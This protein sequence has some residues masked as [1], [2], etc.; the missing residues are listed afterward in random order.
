[1]ASAAVV[2]AGVAQEPRIDDSVNAQSVRPCCI[3]SCLRG[4]QVIVREYGVEFQGKQYKSL[5]KSRS[6]L[7][8]ASGWGRCSSSSRPT[9]RN[10]PINNTRSRARRCAIYTRRS[11]EEGLEQDFKSLHARR[12]ACEA[13][14]GSQAG[15]GWRP[16]K[17]GYDDG[18]LSV[19]TMERPALQRLLADINQGASAQ[20][21][22]ER[23]FARVMRA[24]SRNGSGAP[25]LIG[26]GER[27]GA[28]VAARSSSQPAPRSGRKQPMPESVEIG[29]REHGLRPRRFLARPRYLTLV[30]PHRCLT[31]RKA[32]SPQARVRGRTRLIIRQRTLKG[33]CAVGR[34]LIR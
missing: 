15:E 16:I 24:K 27:S 10:T 31:T 26:G 1:M 18:G 17:T 9:P 20:V 13:F 6:G 3:H 28:S 7:P 29:Q 8:T 4:C 11:S 22:I 32:C 5:L 23:Q 2:Q 21:V 34:R 19:G 14:I 33:R 12:E 30:K 25:G